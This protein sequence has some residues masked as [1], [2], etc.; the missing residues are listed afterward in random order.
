M[1]TSDMVEGEIRDREYV[2]W[3]KPNTQVELH[4]NEFLGLWNCIKME[5][6]PRGQLGV[7]PQPACYE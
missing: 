4:Y 2:F 5:R 7:S 3:E 1:I 6:A